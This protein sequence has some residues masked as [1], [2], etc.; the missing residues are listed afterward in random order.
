M[1]P[2]CFSNYYLNEPFAAPLI[3][4]D[5]NSATLILLPVNPRLYNEAVTYGGCMPVINVSK[6][7][8]ITPS[9]GSASSISLLPGPLY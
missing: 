5:K 1:T 2:I 6:K 9:S 4:S 8:Y 7:A 3:I